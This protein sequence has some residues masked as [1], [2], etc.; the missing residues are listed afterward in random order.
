[1]TAVLRPAG[2]HRLGLIPCRVD[3]TYVWPIAD[4]S[5]FVAGLKNVKRLDTLTVS[6]TPETLPAQPEVWVMRYQ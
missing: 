6:V 2:N 5:G 1:M 4:E 3:L